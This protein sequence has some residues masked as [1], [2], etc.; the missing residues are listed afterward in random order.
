MNDFC[1]WCNDACAFD[2]SVLG[3]PQVFRE[4]IENPILSGS[5][6]NGQCPTNLSPVPICPSVK[7]LQK[8]T[9]SGLSV[10]YGSFTDVRY[11]WI[12]NVD[13]INV[14]INLDNGGEIKLNDGILRMTAML[15]HPQNPTTQTN[16]LSISK[17][18]TSGSFTIIR[19][20]WNNNGTG[21]AEEAFDTSSMSKKAVFSLNVQELETKST[22]GSSFTFIDGV[23]IG[24]VFFSVVSVS[25][26]VSF[27]LNR[28]IRRG[29]GVGIPLS[30]LSKLYP[31]PIMYKYEMDLPECE[32]EGARVPISYEEFYG[33]SS[34]KF[35][36]TSYFILLPGHERFLQNG[37]LP[38]FEV[39]TN[40]LD[41]GF[42]ESAE[43][44][45]KG[46]KYVSILKSNKV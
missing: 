17:A 19:I 39:G 32:F 28:R 7:T 35:I 4:P 10:S 11:Y 13:S 30:N 27:W 22:S 38:K 18:R 15:S 20:S 21:G 34:H 24:L 45:D 44:K 31:T 23:I 1:A 14:S 41:L 6:K 40:I 29:Q 8:G 36:S 9:T 2:N 12:S 16:P 26:T 3:L 5:L 37:D 42:D 43:K 33:P 25:S 46:N